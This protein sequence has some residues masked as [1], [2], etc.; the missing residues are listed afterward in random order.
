VL[1]SISQIPSFAAEETLGKL[2]KWLRLLGFDVVYGPH[3]GF[4]TD[5]SSEVN[6]RILLTRTLAVHNRLRRQQWVLLIKANEPMEQLKSVLQIL[7]IRREHI[8]PFSRCLAC[9]LP[10]EPAASDD[11]R[12]AVP[13]HVWQHHQRFGRCPGCQKVYWSGSHPRRGYE[14]IAKLFAQR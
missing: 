8:R 2:T 11:I 7:D 12:H 5:F 14:S 13:D 6:G 1:P 10:I 4:A 3:E 9:N